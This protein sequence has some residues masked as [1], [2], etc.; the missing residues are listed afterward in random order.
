[1]RAFREWYARDGKSDVEAMLGLAMRTIKS[2]APTKSVIAGA[3]PPGTVG[4]PLAEGR[5]TWLVN[6]DGDG[7]PFLR[8]VAPPWKTSPKD[9][10][11]KDWTRYEGVLHTDHAIRQEF[12]DPRDVPSTAGKP[13]RMD[14]SYLYDKG[15]GA[16]LEF[17]G[18][19]EFTEE[20]I[21]RELGT[22]DT[23]T[24]R[25]A[26]EPLTRTEE[27]ARKVAEQLDALRQLE[28]PPWFVPLDQE[29]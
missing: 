11:G 17:T 29:S 9:L 2:A 20:Q 16:F 23:W 7:K 22:P 5:A 3:K 21:Y 25:A 26:D 8:D 6:V 12:F 1:M 27:E 14:L 10:E 15:Q 18:G 19:R 13:Y 28:S 24:H 4:D